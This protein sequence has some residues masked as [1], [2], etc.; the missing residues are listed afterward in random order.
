MAEETTE[1]TATETAATETAT[2]GGDAAD[3]AAVDAQL[4]AFHAGDSDATTGTAD[5]TAAADGKDADDGAS[6]DGKAADGKDRTDA[7]PTGDAADADRPLSKREVEACK[8]FGLDPDATKSPVARKLAEERAAN[9]RLRGRIRALGK[10]SP[11]A[12]TGPGADAASAAGKPNGGAG[13]E[14][15]AGPVELSITS[16]DLLDV[17]VAAQKLQGLVASINQAIATVRREV[18]AGR[19]AQD[20]D[21]TAQQRDATAAE[22]FNSLPADLF[23][24]HLGDGELSAEEAGS[25]EHQARVEIVEEAI[26]MVQRA[27]AKGRTLDFK[28]AMQAALG[29]LYPEQTQQAAQRR[30]ADEIARRRRGQGVPPSGRRSAAPPKSSEEK[31]L[32]DIDSELREYLQKA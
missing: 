29:V 24:E 19:S 10:D 31:D 3:I 21:A 20:A 17:D 4:K 12:S 11:N 32:A 2:P 1:T 16:D 18:A 7:K 8:Y 15:A 28:A 26:G 5:S 6:T 14:G 22:F 27:Q 30:T 9:D 23:A 13:S 25:P